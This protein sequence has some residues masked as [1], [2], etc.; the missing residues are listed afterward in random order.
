M[1]AAEVFAASEAIDDGKVLRTAV[2]RLLR[3]NV[4]LIIA[5]DS[6]DLYTSLSTQQNAV[7]RS[8]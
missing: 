6:K 8:I 4:R 1:A 5:V 2:A 7:D 3:M